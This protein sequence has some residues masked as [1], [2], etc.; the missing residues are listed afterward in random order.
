MYTRKMSYLRNYFLF[1]TIKTNDKKK[2]DLFKTTLKKAILL[3]YNI[4]RA[5][6]NTN[7]TYEFH[8]FISSFLFV[9]LRQQS[10]LREIYC[11]SVPTMVPT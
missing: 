11:C 2:I 9:L 1:Y 4:F 3:R 10:R 6:Y 5:Q 8:I 7:A